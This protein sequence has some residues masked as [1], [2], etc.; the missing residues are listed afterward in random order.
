MGARI[1]INS[2]AGTADRRPSVERG[3]TAA[4]LAGPVEWID[5][6][7]IADAARDAVEEGA[8]LVIAG[9]GDGTISAVA[10]ALAGSE[11]SL[12]I[13]PLGTL[14]HFAR[15]LG[16]PLDLDEAA[17]LIA[18]GHKR[19]VDV[20]EVNGR[21]FVNNSAIGVYPLMVVDRDAQQSRL[22][23]SKRWAMAVAAARTLFRFSSQKLTVTVDDRKARIDTPLLFVGNND[24]RLQMPGAGTREAIDR[25]ELFVLVL[26]RQSRLG[27]LV[28]ALRSLAGRARAEDSVTI[29]DV[30]RIVVASRSTF[31]TIS[32]DGETVRMKQPLDYRIR[33]KAVT[34]I[35]P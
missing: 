15:D 7:A 13:L 35:A 31:L 29:D 22:G 19:Q 24:Y 18:A 5:G 23:R 27:F 32:L 34:V 25:G 4:G 8:G 16:I 12:G 6:G 10:G 14:N 28:A 1:L 11:T 26:R 33:P 17:Q 9:G 20:A 30:H 2:G 21:V 3:L